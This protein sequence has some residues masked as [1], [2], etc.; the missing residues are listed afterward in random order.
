LG[1]GSE[2]ALA[3]DFIY[4]SENA[5][6]GLPEIKLGL[7]PGFGGTQRLPRLI[8]I[9]KAKE[10]IYTGKLITAAEAEK[11]ASSTGCCPRMR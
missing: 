11:I 10:M 1:G 9:N 6:F 5:T 3:G 2:M 4:A 7:I 8:G